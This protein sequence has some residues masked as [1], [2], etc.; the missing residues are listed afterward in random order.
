MATKEKQPKVGV[1]MTKITRSGTTVTATWKVPKSLGK[2]NAYKASHL[3]IRKA[4]SGVAS[5]GYYVKGLAKTSAGV[6]YAGKLASMTFTRSSFYPKTSRKVSGITITVAPY[7][8]ACKAGGVHSASL[9]YAFTKPVKPTVS[10]PTVNAE[11][12]HISST[13]TANSGTDHQERYDTHIVS[14]VETVCYTS[15]RKSIS[16]VTNEY[17]PTAATYTASYDATNYQQLGYDD[18]IHFKVSAFNRGMWGNSD[19]VTQHLYLSYP[20]QATIGDIDVSSVDNTG[21]VTIS[22]NTNQT[23]EH[24]VTRVVLELLPDT[25]YTDASQIPATAVWTPTDSVDDGECKALASSVAELMPEA[26]HYSWIRVKTINTVE[27]VLYRYSE[28]IRIKAL[29]TPAPTAADESITIV[30]AK[31]G[32]DGESAVVTLGWNESG[33]DDADGTELTWSDDS[34]AW[35]STEEPDAYEFTWSDGQLVDGSTTY[36]DSAE[37][38]IKS[39]EAGVPVYIRARRYLDGDTRT[40]SPYSNVKMTIPSAAPDGVVLI[41]PPYVATG[42]PVGVEWTFGG[43]GVQTSWVLMCNGSPIDQG[44][45]TTGHYEIPAATVAKRAVNG[46]LK[47]SVQVSTGGDPAVSEV[48]TVTIRQAPTLA[49]TTVATLTAQPMG[50]S[51]T[52]SELCD[53]RCVLT[54]NGIDGQTAAGMEEV[55]PG[56]VVWSDV[57]SPA[58]TASGS[59]WTASADIPTR[60]SIQ[61]GV[62]YTL[63]VTATSRDTGL[64]SSAQTA[65]V[66]VD[67]AHKAPY[68]E[69][70]AT[71]TPHNYI[72]RY[73]VHQMQA[74]ID[75]HAVIGADGAAETDVFDIYRLTADGA[76]LIGEGYPLTYTVTDAYAPFGTEVDLAYRIAIRTADGDTAFDD[77]YY[78]LYGDYMRFDWAGGWLELPYNIAISDSYSKDVDVRKHIDGSEGAYYNAGVSRSGKLNSVLIRADNRADIA[79]ARA[80]ASYADALFVRTPDG[81]AYEADVQVND[82]ST[83]GVLLNLSISTRRVAE[84]PAYMLPPI[85]GEDEEEGG[86]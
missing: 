56:Y 69:G 57:L 61:D 70:Y 47:L 39:L 60:R 80:L 79:R 58:W 82:M 10:Y 25:E 12:G 32:A 62:R 2:D 73:G 68:P 9:T 59:N 3:Y 55:M 49:I 5:E 31:S 30:D 72:D 24:D 19:S 37:I 7:N 15:G 44:S 67:Y 27:G 34:N 29:E 43:G 48:Q 33:T 22:I 38:T 63:T 40:Y 81:S 26:G 16:T 83:E 4:I 18:Y 76:S 65:I 35:R 53:L 54:C 46:E 13:V 17:N 86:E 11:N 42:A 71:I 1:K 84:T 14:T 45:G 51:A 50:F 78:D 85:A 41:A 8:S 77:V 64:Q 23:T 66:T 28:A 75:L 52:V 21:K 6:N 74:I 36:H 20:A